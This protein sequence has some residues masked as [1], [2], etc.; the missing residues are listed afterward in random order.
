MSSVSSKEA[1]PSAGKIRSHTLQE[2]QESE[3]VSLLYGTISLDT[4]LL[5]RSRSMIRDKYL[6]TNLIG[7]QSS[8][9]NLCI[10]FCTKISWTSHRF[11]TEKT[12]DGPD[13]GCYASNYRNRTLADSSSSL[14][15]RKGKEL[16][17]QVGRH[18]HEP[19]VLLSTVIHR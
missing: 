4:R 13:P 5:S 17:V 19:L 15:L 16:E 2:G 18:T 1:I 10:N 7:G 9:S 3:W 6:R 8:T 14:Q 12:Y 11:R